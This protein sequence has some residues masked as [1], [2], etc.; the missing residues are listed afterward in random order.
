M[1]LDIDFTNLENLVKNMGASSV[2]W[3]SDVVVTHVETDWKIILETKGID[4]DINDVEIKSNGLLHYRGEQILLYIKAA[5]SGSF[6]KF[7]FT[8]CSTLKNMKRMKRFYRYVVTQRKDG[9]FLMGVKN[10]YGLQI[11]EQLE[12]LNVCQ[13]CLDWY[14][15]N[16]RHRNYCSVKN[17]DIEELFRHLTQSPI[18][19]KPIYTDQDNG[20][21]TALKKVENNT[22]IAIPSETKS[23]PEF[24]ETTHTQQIKKQFI[25]E[26]GVATDTESGLMWL[27]F[28][29][30]QHW[31]NG[32]SFGNP[33][34]INW[35]T[36]IKTPQTF[37]QNGGYKNYAD[38]RIPSIGEL[39]MLID[40][41][42]FVYSKKIEF[43]NFH[44]TKYWSA[45]E[46]VDD[47]EYAWFVDLKQGTLWGSKKPFSVNVTFKLDQLS[48]LLVRDPRKNLIIEEN[49]K[50]VINKSE[51]QIYKIPFDIEKTT[52][53]RIDADTPIQ[54]QVTSN[55][56]KLE[57]QKVNN[58]SVASEDASVRIDRVLNEFCVINSLVDVKTEKTTVA[59]PLL[60]DEATQDFEDMF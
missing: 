47:T 54:A 39:T 58:V 45:T 60:K 19:Q 55:Q 23:I 22:Q 52:D 51:R 10:G 17:F 6:P 44:N 27:Q 43:L 46:N 5:S 50:Q 38:W 48:V 26:D 40:Q 12:R 14:N 36:A 15:K 24:T 18:S 41:L 9:Y 56:N 53:T 7:H 42:S 31:K 37:N 34:K 13:N 32:H 16:Y 33:E 59:V 29:Y 25:V 35:K 20:K 8:D 30:G 1:K 2:D 57:P 21:L 11:G 3:V 49:N 4:V 28:A